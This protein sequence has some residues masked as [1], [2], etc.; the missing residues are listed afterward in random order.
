MRVYVVV[1]GDSPAGIASRDSMA[2]CPKCCRDMVLHPGNAHKERVVHPNGFVSFK[3]LRV[4]EKLVLP[5][6]WFEPRFELLPPAYFAS[7]PYHNGVT[8]S[9]FGEL[10]PQVLHDFKALDVAADKLRAFTESG[11]SIGVVVEAI[12]VAVQPAIDSTI[13]SATQYAR[14]AQEDLRYVTSAATSHSEVRNALESA[15]TNAQHAIH[16]LYATL[17]PPVHK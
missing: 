13:A 15:L 4:G 10:A 16:D 1:A 2:G 3:E 7:L 8:P 17:Q 9:P 6:K 14:D 12:R 5:D 11:V